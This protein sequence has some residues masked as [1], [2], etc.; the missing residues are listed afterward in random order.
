MASAESPNARRES[1][2]SQPMQ[3]EPDSSL[4]TI[5]FSTSSALETRAMS[6]GSWFGYLQK[7]DASMKKSAEGSSVESSSRATSAR[8]SA[9]NS[10]DRILEAANLDLLGTQSSIH[11]LLSLKQARD[12]SFGDLGG[13]SVNSVDYLKKHGFMQDGTRDPNDKNGEK[14]RG[15]DST[16]KGKKTANPSRGSYGDALKAM[17]RFASAATTTGSSSISGKKTPTIPLD[18]KV[19]HTQQATDIPNRPPVPSQKGRNKSNTPKEFVDI[20]DE[21]VLC[22]RGGK[23]NHHPGNKR[24]RQVIKEWKAKYRVISAKT[25][26]T[27]VSRKIVSEV[28]QYGGRF[29]KKDYS[30]GLYYVMPENEARRKTSQALRETKELKWLD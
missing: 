22:G 17:G 25:E 23:S 12:N 18:P 15:K 29:L 9:G 26:K 28:Y 2:S 11:S 6:S 19:N 16:E 8:G 30:N 1:P 24:Y 21:D 13:S 4:T 14:G 20:K 7:D 27:G 10:I 3:P 5:S